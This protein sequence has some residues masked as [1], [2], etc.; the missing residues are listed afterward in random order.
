MRSENARCI[1]YFEALVLDVPVPL[2][3]RSAIATAGAAVRLV[4]K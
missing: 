2:A 1:V 3:A 4:L